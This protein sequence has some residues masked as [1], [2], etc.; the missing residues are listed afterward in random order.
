MSYVYLKTKANTGSTTIDVIPLKATT[1]TIATDK[2]IPAKAIPFSGLATGESTT[3]A[4]DM[5]MS[6]KNITIQGVILPAAITKSHT[7][8]AKN[9]TAHEIAQMIHSGVDSTGLA[10]HQALD[11]LVFL[12]P[13]TVNESYVEVTERNIPFSFASRGADN[14]L[15]NF[16][17]P[18]AEDFPTTSTS[19]GLKGFIRQF[20]SDFSA[21]AV[22]VAFSMTFE[23]ATV[24]P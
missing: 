1:I 13:S 20:S 8:G 18:L 5:G 3:A 10:E 12:I 6:S 4:L 22:E 9:F 19:E 23:V 21:E 14:T 11:E 16:Q 7:A 24:F 2:T 15:D 17:V